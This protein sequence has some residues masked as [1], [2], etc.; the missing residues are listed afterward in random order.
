M[1]RQKQAGRKVEGDRQKQTR[2]GE[3]R[4]MQAQAGRLTGRNW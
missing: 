1:G 3:G 4:G 2:A